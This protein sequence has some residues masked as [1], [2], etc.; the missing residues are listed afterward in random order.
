MQLKLEKDTEFLEETIFNDPMSEPIIY[1]LTIKIENSIA[2]TWLNKM[3]QSYLPDCIGEDPISSQINELMLESEDD[4]ASFAVQ[5]TFA[6]PE[7]F[8]NKG[9]EIVN[10][11]IV[12]MDNDFRNRYVYF[13][14]KMRLLHLVRNSHTD[15]E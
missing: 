5:L 13:G 7:M 6:S 1:N 4:D 11:L 15:F 3:E 10:K 2:K 9:V 12:L 8:E 14:T